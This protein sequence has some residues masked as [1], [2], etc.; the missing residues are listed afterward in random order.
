[1][2]RIVVVF[3][4]SLFLAI[5]AVAQTEQPMAVPP[6]PSGVQITNTP[7]EQDQRIKLVLRG[8]LRNRH[9]LLRLRDRPDGRKEREYED[10]NNS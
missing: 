4:L 10:H 2:L 3:I 1:M 7:E 9:G 8:T 5:G 6:R